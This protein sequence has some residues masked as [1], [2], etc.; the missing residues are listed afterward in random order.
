[1]ELEHSLGYSHRP[2]QDCVE[3]L[4]GRNVETLLDAGS[5]EGETGLFLAEQGFVVQG[6]DPSADSVARAQRRAEEGRLGAEFVQGH[7][8]AIPFEHELFDAVV[9]VL[10]LD[11][12]TPRELAMAIDWF[13]RH[14]RRGGSLFALFHPYAPREDSGYPRAYRD[15]ELRRMFLDFQLMQFQSYP[16]GY[17]GLFFRR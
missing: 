5:G 7:W 12:I 15:N 4:T 17:R 6:F 16:G 2:L 3:F 1:M 10:T 11:C 8:D 14:V 13:G 9:A